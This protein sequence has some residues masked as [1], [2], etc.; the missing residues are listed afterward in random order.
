MGLKKIINLHEKKSKMLDQHYLLKEGVTNFFFK[1]NEN[2]QISL[3][4]KTLNPQ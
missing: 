3:T 2:Y 4:L 1:S